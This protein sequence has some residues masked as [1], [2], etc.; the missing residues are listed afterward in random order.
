MQH[1]NYQR[2]IFHSQLRQLLADHHKE[3][4]LLQVHIQATAYIAVDD[5]KCVL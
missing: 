5:A 1:N 2:F 3:E 4:E